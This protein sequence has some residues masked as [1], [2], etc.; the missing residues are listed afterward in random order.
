M[1]KEVKITTKKKGSNN[2]G[3]DSVVVG[4]GCVQNERENL[5]EKRLS[6]CNEI[7]QAR[8]IKFVLSRESAVE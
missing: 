2:I 7:L 1:E 5:R 8:D 3:D 4:V 6:K